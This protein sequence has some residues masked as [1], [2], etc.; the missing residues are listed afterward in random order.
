[1]NSPWKTSFDNLVTKGSLVVGVVFI[2]GL[3]FQILLHVC[4]S[5]LQREEYPLVLVVPVHWVL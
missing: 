5:S 3:L 1:M 4:F 2:F